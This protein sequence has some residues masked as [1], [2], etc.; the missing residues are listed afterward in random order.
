MPEP[1]MNAAVRN[2]VAAFST[3]HAADLHGTDSLKDAHV[4]AEHYADVARVLRNSLSSNNVWVTPLPDFTTR[5]ALTPDTTIDAIVTRVRSL[6][7]VCGDLDPGPAP[8]TADCTRFFFNSFLC[9]LL[10]ALGNWAEQV[11]AGGIQMENT[12][13]S[14]RQTFN[15]LDCA[16]LMKAIRE[17]D[18]FHPTGIP[19]VGVCA[20]ISGA[21]TVKDLACAVWSATRKVPCVQALACPLR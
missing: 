18:V 8:T 5:L 2:A 10:V 12:L 1:D 14:L 3:T 4:K 13:L 6:I 16:L 21:S 9:R 20:Q 7:Q 15:E 11:P 19:A 17:V